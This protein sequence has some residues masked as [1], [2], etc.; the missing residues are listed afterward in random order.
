[1]KNQ[2][3]STKLT[4]FSLAAA[5]LVCFG[6]S[7]N[8]FAADAGTTSASSGAYDL[9]N[10]LDFVA[11][12]QNKNDLTVTTSSARA[13]SLNTGGTSATGVGNASSTTSVNGATTNINAT[14]TT[15]LSGATTNISATGTTS[16]S[17]DTT[18]ISA[19]TSNQTSPAISIIG[20]NGTQVP[21]TNTGL[22]PN[23][24]TGTGVLITGSS[25]GSGSD[26]YISSQNGNA[27]IS[28]TNTG[29]TIISPAG[30]GTGGGVIDVSSTNNY[31]QQGAYNSGSVTNNFGNGSSTSSGNVTNTIGTSVAGGGLLENTIGGGAGNSTNSFG[32]S[33]ASGASST[34]NIG[35]A[36]AG[37]T[38][39]NT[40]GGG[41]GVVTNSIGNSNTSSTLS[42]QAGNSAS[43][44]SNGVNTSTT[45]GSLES[46]VGESNIAGATG[47][48]STTSG[49]VLSGATGTY[50]TVDGNGKISVTTGTATESSTNM[51]ITNGLGNT[52]G[53]VVNESQATLSGGTRSSSM[54]L[55]DNG[56]TFSNAATGSAIQ[57][58]GVANGTAPTDA[59][60]V[61]QMRSG[62]ASAAALAGLPALDTNKDFSIAI[63]GATYHG[64]QAAAIGLSARINKQLVVKAGTTTSYNGAATNIGMGYSW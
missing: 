45:S 12:L 33:S 9:Q 27:A 28:V 19:T 30:T 48:T 11:A 53:L 14:G 52:H 61:R 5:T 35:S 10:Y 43:N 8:T 22:Y 39:I 1:M 50:A 4:A 49:A 62:V 59:V 16:I 6:V 17:G 24:P 63:A 3:F 40:I 15:S 46:G 55:N 23:I 42:M 38:S 58:H 7:K 20:Q 32:N 56:A 34:N 21:N 44:L 29:V 18:N 2:K 54:T 36:V 64:Y 41:A 25:N 57:V 31:G 37:S 47:Y 13:D 51:T 26:V 60:N